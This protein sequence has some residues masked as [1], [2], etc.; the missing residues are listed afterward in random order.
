MSKKLIFSSFFIK[1]VAL[2]AMTLDHIAIVLKSLYFDN[3]SLMVLQNIFRIIGRF[4]LPLF[5]FM[6][7]EGVIHTKNFKK[8]I[9]RLGCMALI[10]TCGLIFITYSNYKHYFNSLQNNGNI[11]LDLTLVAITVYILKNCKSFKKL[12]ILL[13]LGISIA[14]FSCKCYEFYIGNDI[15]W[16]PNWLY[17]QFDFY[18]ILLGI[19]YYYAKPISIKF[20]NYIANKNNID[21]FVFEQSQVTQ[22]STNIFSVFVLIVVSLL[23]YSIGFFNPN[24]AFW[25]YTCQ[26]N[27]IFA[28]AFLLLYNGK[29]G[30]NSKWFQYGCYLY[31][32]LHILILGLIILLV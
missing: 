32:P 7:V 23:H 17:L 4:S 1:I 10:I 12:F 11:F 30:Y 28:G 2:L 21:P 3:Y 31:Y 6:I 13:P 18:S 14:S 29:R 26:L 8:Y 25:D 5:I 16:Y 20:I 9:L 19:G 15:L 22:L 24:W 27:A